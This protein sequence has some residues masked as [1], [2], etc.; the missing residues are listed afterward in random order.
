MC[1]STPKVNFLPRSG[2]IAGPGLVDFKIFTPTLQKCL[3]QP[4]KVI[5]PLCPGQ[6]FKFGFQYVPK[7][8]SLVKI[9]IFKTRL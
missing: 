7:I 4:L 1:L 2:Q 8:T 6:N 5:F 9:S 3:Y